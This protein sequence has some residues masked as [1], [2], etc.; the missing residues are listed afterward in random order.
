[1]PGTPEGLAED[2]LIGRLAEA[3]D[4]EAASIDL[5]QQEYKDV[6]E[7]LQKFAPDASE[8][9]L[10]LQKLD[11]IQEDV[12]ALRQRIVELELQ[13]P[14]AMGWLVAPRLR[15]VFGPGARPAPP[16]RCYAKVCSCACRS[17][18]EDI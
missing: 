7:E 12:N 2:A 11:E 4:K 6:W 1:M 10:L 14:G 13:A 17:E 18:A 9:P 15:R 3:V 5:L 16:V 8:R